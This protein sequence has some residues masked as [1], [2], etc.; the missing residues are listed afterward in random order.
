MCNQK[1]KRSKLGKKLGRRLSREQPLD[2]QLNVRLT[3]KDM[4]VLRDFCFRYDLSASHVIRDSLAIL[5]V[6]PDWH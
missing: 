1:K 6:I 2:Q 3:Q 5:G 4:E